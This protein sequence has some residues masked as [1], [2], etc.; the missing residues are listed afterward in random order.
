M[1]MSS[2]A[3]VTGVSLVFVMSNHAA[4][5]LVPVAMLLALVLGVLLY[6]LLGC[7]DRLWNWSVGR[8]GRLH[9]A[10]LLFFMYIP[11]FVG[12]CLVILA[13]P[14][15]LVISS[16]ASPGLAADYR[17]W[18][19]DVAAVSAMIAWGRLIFRKL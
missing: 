4:L 7:G 10:F 3:L 11:I 1:I 5:W 16:Y 9:A 6:L 13:Y 12:L 19:L 2:V 14:L 17:R 8:S 18:V 15:G